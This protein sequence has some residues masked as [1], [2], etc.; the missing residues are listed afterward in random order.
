MIDG[1]QLSIA[2]RMK[3]SDNRFL[4]CEIYFSASTSAPKTP[5]IRL[6]KLRNFVFIEASEDLKQEN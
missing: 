6:C 2:A 5:L 1:P 4:H 3:I